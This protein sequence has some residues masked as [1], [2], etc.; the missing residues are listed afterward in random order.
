M[1]WWRQSFTRTVVALMVASCWDTMRIFSFKLTMGHP[2]FHSRWEP[3]VCLHWA[4]LN[5][6]L[7]SRLKW[8]LTLRLS[9][10]LSSLPFPPPLSK[11]SKQEE[12]WE[13]MNASVRK[14]RC[15]IE[16]ELFSYYVGKDLRTTVL[17]SWKLGPVSCYFQFN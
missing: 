9:F 1:T 12:K 13:V 5:R 14:D 6:T 7:V 10:Y 3:L 17:F 15:C 16:F 8:R 2:K 4:L 11:L